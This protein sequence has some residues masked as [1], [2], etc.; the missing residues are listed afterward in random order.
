M[1]VTYHEMNHMMGEMSQHWIHSTPWQKM[2]ALQTKML[3]RSLEVQEK[4]LVEL[5]KLNASQS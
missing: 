5:Q 3:I 4:I 2:L 1:A